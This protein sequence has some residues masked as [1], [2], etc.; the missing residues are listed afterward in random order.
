MHTRN[1]IYENALRRARY[2][3]VD[4]PTV[5]L[6]DLGWAIAITIVL[7]LGTIA[8]LEGVLALVKWLA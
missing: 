4:P 1:R 6:S 2:N 5:T 8:M 7:G 3:P